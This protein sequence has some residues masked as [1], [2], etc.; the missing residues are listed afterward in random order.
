MGRWY[1]GEGQTNFSN[2]PSFRALAGPHKQV[3]QLA[4]DAVKLDGQGQFDAANQKI[5]EME[6]V[7]VE[8][9]SLLKQLAEDERRQH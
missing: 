2:D 5:V 4:M 1:D 7:S 9:V 3:H 6:A 8:V